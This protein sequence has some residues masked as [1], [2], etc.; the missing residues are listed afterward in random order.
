M[1]AFSHQIGYLAQAIYSYVA[2]LFGEKSI[3]DAFFLPF[4]RPLRPLA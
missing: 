4:R 2:N 3:D 1:K